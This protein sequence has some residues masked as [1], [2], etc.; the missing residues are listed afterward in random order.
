[1]LLEP[2]KFLV[3]S[4][5]CSVAPPKYTRETSPKARAAA[6]TDKGNNLETYESQEATKH[7][8]QPTRSKGKRTA[9]QRKREATA[10]H[11]PLDKRK[12]KRAA[13]PIGGAV[14]V[15]QK[16][17]SQ[18]ADYLTKLV[19]DGAGARAMGCLVSWSYHSMLNI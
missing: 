1:M 5:G 18:H 7:S 13:Q 12:R 4:S 14:V 11:V 9:Q 8:Q 2:N 10:K 6:T 16:E 17:L 3:V 19:K 15:G